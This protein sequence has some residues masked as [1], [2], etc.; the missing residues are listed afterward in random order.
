MIKKLITFLI[1]IATILITMPLA[2]ATDVTTSRGI[3]PL[4]KPQLAPGLPTTVGKDECIKRYA[5]DAYEFAD[6]DYIAKYVWDDKNKVCIG[7]SGSTV[8]QAILQRITG[9][10]L[11]ISGGLAV[12]VIAMSG[13][14]YQ[15]ARG[16]QQQME[17]MKEMS[18]N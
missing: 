15:G 1:L 17:V 5:G 7:A 12:I 16:N 14:L 6:D 10:L 4:L 18:T 13:F 2:F 3:D 11:M 8:I 9:A